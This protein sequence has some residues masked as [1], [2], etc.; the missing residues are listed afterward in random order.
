MTRSRPEPGTTTTMPVRAIT[1]DLD[2]T[3][4]PI[5][6]VIE[7]A[8]QAVMAWFERTAPRVLERFDID[9]LRQLRIEVS[10]DRPDMAHD[11]G[12]LRRE[13]FV[14]ALEQ[15]RYP[16][17]LADQAFAVFFRARCQV[18]LFPEVP[19][20]LERW[21]SVYA[22][23]AV[24]NGNADLEQIG[25]AHYF[26]VVIHA[27]RHGA[28]KPDVSLFHAAVSGLGI[29]PD[30]AVHIGDHPREDIEGARAAG[31]HAI[32]LNRSGMEW[33]LDS[34]PPLSVS[35]LLEVEKWLEQGLPDRFQTP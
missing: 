20:L 25:L 28:S 6:P 24:T 3:L 13:V 1:L 31:L 12:A 26:P 17:H 32:W 18:E 27:G 15:C 33:P 4:W 7:R 19:A 35:N 21:Q 5:W 2:E 22:L 11:L 34:E 23:A 8:E 30:Q 14:R 10:T 29:R 16:A 9:S